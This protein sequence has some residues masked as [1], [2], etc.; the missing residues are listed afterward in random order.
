MTF[1]ICDVALDA[2]WISAYCGVDN[3]LCYTEC[4]SNNYILF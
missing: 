3:L 1:L 2:L 4:K